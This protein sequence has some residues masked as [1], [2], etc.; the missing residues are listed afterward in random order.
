MW[1]FLIAVVVFYL[2]ALAGFLFAMRSAQTDAAAAVE[3]NVI[4]F[5][6]PRQRL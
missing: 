1:T 4:R 2:V 3:D 6:L 5:E